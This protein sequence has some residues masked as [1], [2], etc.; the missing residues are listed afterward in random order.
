[1]HAGSAEA[2]AESV[3]QRDYLQG[4]LRLRQQLIAGAKLWA[5]R[6]YSEARL[7][8]LASFVSPT[9][10]SSLWLAVHSRGD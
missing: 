8:L 7:V 9:V 4:R 2:L 1:M 5:E 6:L 3:F 10:L